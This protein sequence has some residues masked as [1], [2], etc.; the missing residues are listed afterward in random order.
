MHVAAL[1]LAATV[2]V[3]LDQSTKALALAKL[4][5]GRVVGIGFVAIRTV[6]NRRMGWIIWNSEAAPVVLLL[7]EFVLLA[8]VVQF[9]G[10]FT[11]AVAPTALGAAL[12]GASSNLIDRLWRGGVV[13]FIDLK[14]W[15]VFNLADVAIVLGVLISAFQL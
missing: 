4:R 13:D 2:I 9:G 8:A 1:L 14:V 5:E 10:F 6:L 15:P 7:V 12:G 3:A 11:D